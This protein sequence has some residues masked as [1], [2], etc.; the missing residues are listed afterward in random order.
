MQ[1]LSRSARTVLDTRRALQRRGHDEAVIDRVITAL[2]A[3]GIL[4]DKQFASS[5]AAALARRSPAA[6]RFLEER[7]RRHGVPDAEAA[8]AAAEAAGNPI[9]A[10]TVVAAR[11]IRSLAS[12]T[13]ETR[14]RRIQGRL[15]RRGFDRDVIAEV[16]RRID[17]DPLE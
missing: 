10:A 7:L 8:E 14:K 11:A 17:Q 3:D 9:E 15:I 1:R 4:D 13:P 5:A 16:M 12:C 2:V 6:A